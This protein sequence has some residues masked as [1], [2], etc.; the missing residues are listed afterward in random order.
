MDRKDYGKLIV[1]EGIDGTGKSTQLALLASYLKSQRFSVIMTKEPTDGPIGQ[2]IRQLYTNRKAFSDDE[3]LALFIADRR[4]HVAQCILPALE[5]GKIVL[6]DRYFLSTMAYQGAK[7]MDPEK[8][9]QMNSFAPAPDCA[10]LLTAPVET[11]T[12][13]ITSK[14]GESLNDFESID[15]LRRVSAV[16]SQM[17][18]PW[19]SRI[20]A[21]QSL[22]AVHEQ[23]KQIVLPLFQK[24]LSRRQV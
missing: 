1:F 14:R 21:S 7:G 8:I 12:E 5:A 6:C 10:L 23:I 22:D 24:T 19:I 9:Q 4:E 15:N 11:G 16:F 20:D 18:M 2:Q 3:E 17:K 13:R